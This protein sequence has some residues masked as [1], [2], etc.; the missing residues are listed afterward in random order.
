MY[1]AFFTFFSSAVHQGEFFFFHYKDIMKASHPWDKPTLDKRIMDDKVEKDED[2]KT[3]CKHIA[4]DVWYSVI[5]DPLCSQLLSEATDENI[6]IF[7]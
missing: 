6:V 7:R 5:S 2:S 3:F 4:E 1:V